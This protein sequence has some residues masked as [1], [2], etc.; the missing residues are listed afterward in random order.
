[1]ELLERYEDAGARLAHTRAAMLEKAMMNAEQE[2]ER[3]KAVAQREFGIWQSRSGW[4]RASTILLLLVLVF[5]VGRWIEGERLGWIGAAASLVALLASL[6]LM[7][8]ANARRHHAMRVNALYERGLQRV[9][10]DS[11]QSVYTGEEFVG[12]GHLYA[13]DLNVVGPNSLFG[14]LALTRTALGHKALA[15]WLLH[16]G[17]TSVIEARQESVRELTDDYDLREKVALLGHS[18]FE[19]LPANSFEEWLSLEDKALPRW[20]RPF[21]F[22]LTA[23]WIAVLAAGHL[24]HVGSGLLLRNVLA[25]LAVQGLVSF[26]FRQTVRAELQ[27][28]ERLTSHVTILRQGLVI[29]QHRHFASDALVE[30][31]TGV[32]E[33]E[34][35]LKSLDRQLGIVEQRSKEQFYLVSLLFGTGTQVAISLRNWKREH[36]AAMERWLRAWSEFDT[37]VALSTYAAEHV[38][39]AYPDLISAERRCAVFRAREML[40]PL[41]PKTTAVPND[42]TLDGETQVMVISGSNMAG[43]STLVA[44]DWSERRSCED[45][46]AGTG[47]F[48]CDEHIADWSVSGF[49]RLVG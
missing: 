2:Y 37:F 6:V 32:S 36:G 10:G 33:S 48:A 18:G 20:L 39:N 25:V 19:K 24:L 7:L 4:L 12:A 26:R 41:L 28:A 11:M 31:A 23:G 38:E 45:G 22:A 49:E 13:Q 30:L 42:L 34:A 5:A 21:L 17:E 8:R 3:R 46:C 1:M 14:M 27:A 16:A 44:S 35:M 47:S 43:K 40:H 15:A 9:R 29:L